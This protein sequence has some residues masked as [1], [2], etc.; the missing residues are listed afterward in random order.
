MGELYILDK[1]NLTGGLENNMEH[2]PEGI[3]VPID[4]PY[5][6]TSAD[7]IRKVKFR[8]QRF[9]KDRKLKVGHAG[10]LDPLATGI[11]LVCLGRA[12][13]K[14]EELQSGKKEYVATV[15]FGATT[16]CYDLEKQ[17]DR[18]YPYE[19]ITEVLIKEKLKDFTGEQDQIP[20]LFSAKLI[21]GVRAY[22]YARAGEEKQLK[23][24]RITIYAAEL[25]KYE[26]AEA[27]IRIECSKGTYIRSFAR[28]L[29]LS[30]ESGAHLTALRRS[31]SGNFRD[32]NCLT[33][34]DLESIMKL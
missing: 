29:G 19:H 33:V 10:T 11:L 9:F 4:K 18:T 31:R 3:V 16:P 21:N 12:T 8:S 32:T 6:W 24:A 7:V 27:R 14:A 25:L 20:P 28:D 1:E 23:P 22:E 5:G 34:E 2:Y 30:L 26:N 17:I 15:K 13:K